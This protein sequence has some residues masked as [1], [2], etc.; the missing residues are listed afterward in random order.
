MMRREVNLRPGVIFGGG[1][2]DRNVLMLVNYAEVDLLSPVGF[3]HFWGEI[4]DVAVLITACERW[5]AQKL[6]DDYAEY[7]I[8]VHVKKKS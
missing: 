2:P 6:S 4:Q 1:L 5:G 8:T 7:E 3:Y